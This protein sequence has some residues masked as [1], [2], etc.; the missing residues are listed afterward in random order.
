MKQSMI[1]VLLAL[2]LGTILGGFI[3]RKW[4]PRRDVEYV[5]LPGE[6]VTIEVPSLVQVIERR[7]EQ[8]P[9]EVIELPPDTEY[10][11]GPPVLL[12]CGETTYPYRWHVV[13]LD[14]PETFYFEDPEARTAIAAEGLGL[15]GGIFT[16][17]QRLLTYPH[18]GPLRAIRTD[19]IPILSFWDPP[20]PPKGCD[21]WC[22]MGKVGIG[23]AI[24]FPAGALTCAAIR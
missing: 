6:T 13:S 22:Q 21:F 19:S 18:L 23:A 7:F 17:E 8:L 5:P 15:E 9:P 2:I 10:V 14:A 12:P 16:R 3:I 11:A 1:V 20:V 24:G 4:F